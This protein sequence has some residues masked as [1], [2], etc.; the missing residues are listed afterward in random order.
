VNVS[1]AVDVA[2][3]WVDVVRPP[4]EVMPMADDVTYPAS[5][6][7]KLTSAGRVSV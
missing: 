1:A 4:R 2:N 5:L 3:V 6:L 7:K